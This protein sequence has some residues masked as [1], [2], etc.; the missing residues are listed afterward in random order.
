MTFQAGDRIRFLTTA[1]DGLPLVRYGFVGGVGGS[2]GPVIIMLDGE[3]AGH[4]VSPADIEHVAVTTVELCLEGSDLVED[5]G[6]RR[7]LVHLWQAEADTAGLDVDA[8][9]PIGDGERDVDGCWALARLVAG[10]QEYV[11]R[12]SQTAH[13]P[14]TVRI[15]ADGPVNARAYGI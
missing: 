1:D 12:A 15:H 5:A 6:L 3:I 10:G 8:L 2:E 13:D 11:V 9:H 4:V 14:A 7:G